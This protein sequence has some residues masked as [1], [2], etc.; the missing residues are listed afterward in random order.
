MFR[1][2][3]A[4]G[5]IR[6]ADL[7]L[8]KEVLCLLSY[9]SKWQRRLALPVATRMRLEL[10]TSS[11]TGWRSNQLNYRAAYSYQQMI[12]YNTQHIIVNTFF[13]N[14]DK[15]YIPIF[16]CII[17]LALSS[18]SSSSGV[19]ETAPYLRFSADKTIS[20]ASFGFFDSSGPCRYVQYVFLYLRP[21]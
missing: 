8:T 19:R 16:L 6:T 1:R 4:V 10:T 15:L 13:F 3:G 2:S 20:S 12:L 7:F 9:N 17:R 11:V 18:K 21:S 5:Q 14:H